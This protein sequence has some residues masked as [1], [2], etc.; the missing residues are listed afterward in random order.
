VAFGNAPNEPPAQQAYPVPSLLDYAL[1]LAA[2]ADYIEDDNVGPTT[3]AS[4]RRTL[5]IVQAGY[6]SIENGKP[7]DL[8]QRFGAL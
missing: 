6:E 5:S 1:E 7:I 8:D 3:G 4:E 2:F